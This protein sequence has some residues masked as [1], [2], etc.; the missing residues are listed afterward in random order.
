MV[1]KFSVTG[2]ALVMLT[3]PKTGEQKVKRPKA[4]ID[5]LARFFITFGAEG[6]T[7]SLRERCAA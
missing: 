5:S 7:T 1:S 2:A 3:C 6:I 4:R